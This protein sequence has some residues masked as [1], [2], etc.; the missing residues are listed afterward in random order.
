MECPEELQPPDPKKCRVEEEEE[1]LREEPQD[2]ESVP[3]PSSWLPSSFGAV[4][5]RVGPGSVDS[6]LSG[7]AT[8]PHEDE[9]LPPP[10]VY[11]RDTSSPANEEEDMSDLSEESGKDWKPDM[12]GKLA[13]LHRA[14]A[15]GE[16]PRRLLSKV[17]PSGS[18][19]PPDIDRM[20]LWKVLFNLLSEPERREKLDT[21]NTVEDV[22]RLIRSCSRILVLTGA[23]VSVSCGIPDFRSKD[24]V[25][26]RLAVDFPD[27][28]DP[29]AMFDIHY[30]R[31]DPRPFY[32]FAREI[33]PG[34][35]SPSPCHRFIASL[36]KSGKLLRNY[37]QNIDTL[38]QE[39][40]IER[41]IQCHGSFATA[42]CTVCKRQVAASEIR[43]DIFERR[44]PMCSVCSQSSHS[45]P[46]PVEGQ[47]AASHVPCSSDVDVVAS[48]S[49]GA[50]ASS[51]PSSPS[52]VS[53]L[54]ALPM[55]VMKPDIVFFGEGLP[56]HFHSA[57]T[58][59]KQD[60]DL[61]IV[62][63]SSLKVRPVAL[64]PSS[65]PSGIPQIL[66]NRE[67]L[68]HCTFDVELLGDCD[69]IVN[70]L[71]LELGEGWESPVHAPSLKQSTGLPQAY[72]A[73]R[74][75]M[76]LEERQEM[77]KER[78]ER[79][80]VELEMKDFMDQMTKKEEA[81]IKIMESNVNEPQVEANPSGILTKD[82]E[83][84]TEKIPSVLEITN[85]GT[86]KVNDDG[87][88]NNDVNKGA[89]TVDVEEVNDGD[90]VEKDVA[91]KE[92]IDARKDGELENV[93]ESADVDAGDVADG[94]DV[95]AG[96]GTSSADEFLWRPKVRLG[97][98]EYLPEGHFVFLP[99]ARYVF[100]GA[101]V[102]IEEE[103]DDEDDDEEGS[104]ILP[105]APPEETDVAVE[106]GETPLEAE[107]REDF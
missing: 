20:T 68:P 13:W 8:P 44:I 76:E 85:I 48:S 1:K 106:A 12:S 103:S 65:L 60:A 35:F 33:Y 53:P 56:D 90:I 67:P 28:P 92:E 95:E 22:V 37:T 89:N 7:S 61:L 79:K 105:V 66:I 17:L 32:K 6:G 70:Q 75:Q 94:A 64:I 87:F 16:E 71:C 31:R 107:N 74:T 80:R 100:S 62:I 45:Q 82:S 3:A 58:H 104:L 36:E 86:N 43:E 23:G 41:V 24:G 26:A 40:G 57:I 15:R 14:M 51:C 91:N 9:D 49:T 52:I 2:E 101:E 38:E 19:V 21:V 50:A 59:D 25:Y 30:F 93:D 11:D 88:E 46:N 83:E 102:V 18:V 42:S 34:Q 84:T 27:L 78:E 4:T 97:L 69:T 55:A 96:A 77:E 29:Q 98:A 63:G 10:A 5:N 47:E 99:P 39:A 73:A 54:P 72:I 81:A